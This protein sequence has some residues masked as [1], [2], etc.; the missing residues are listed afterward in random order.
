MPQRG[1]SLPTAGSTPKRSC[2]KICRGRLVQYAASGALLAA[3]WTGRPRQTFKQLLFGV[4]PAVGKLAL[5]CDMNTIELA[6]NT[7]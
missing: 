3:A 4:L 6:L 1:A 7:E 2:L 5:L